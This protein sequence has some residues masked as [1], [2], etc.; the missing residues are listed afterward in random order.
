MHHTGTDFQRKCPCVSTKEKR[1]KELKSA[2]RIAQFMAC[3]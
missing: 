3:C 2:K 1:H